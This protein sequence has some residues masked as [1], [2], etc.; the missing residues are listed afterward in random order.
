[1]ASFYSNPRF[2]IPGVQRHHPTHPRKTFEDA[3]LPSLVPIS[4]T[5]LAWLTRGYGFQT[6]SKG[7]RTWALGGRTPD[8]VLMH[9]SM[10]RHVG[11]YYVCCVCQNVVYGVYASTCGVYHASTCGVYASMRDVYVK[12]VCE[13][14][15]KTCVVCLSKSCVVCM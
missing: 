5:W 8:L 6:L 7:A 9:G 3:Q 10:A 11:K 14:Y 4:L 15:L 13:V 12:I 1:M 2:L